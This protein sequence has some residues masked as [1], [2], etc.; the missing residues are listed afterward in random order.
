MWW[1]WGLCTCVGHVPT[2]MVLLPL[3]GRFLMPLWVASTTEWLEIW[4]GVLFGFGF[5][6][7][8][9]LGV[10]DLDKPECQL[11][12]WNFGTVN[13]Q[14]KYYHCAERLFKAEIILCHPPLWRNKANKGLS[15]HS[16]NTKYYNESIRQ[17]KTSS[18]PNTWYTEVLG[19]GDTRWY[20]WD[21]R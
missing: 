11:C 5:S 1:H 21:L 18:T 12:V 9:T 4:T 7:N 17:E 8:I 16:W 3:R 10:I 15:L 6:T 13:R 19:R 2:L 14:T 20:A